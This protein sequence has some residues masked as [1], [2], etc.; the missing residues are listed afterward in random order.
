MSVLLQLLAQY[1]A[2]DPQDPFNKYAF[3]LELSK[4]DP[5]QGLSLFEELQNQ[6]PDYLP[7]YYTAASLASDLGKTELATTLLR[8][9]IIIAKAQNN[10]KTVSELSNALN[11]LLAEED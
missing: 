9:G 4:S 8:K 5:V 1:L 10:L 2:E 11:N 7:T 3:A 6:A